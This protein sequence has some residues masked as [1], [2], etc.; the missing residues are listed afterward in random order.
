MKKILRCVSLLLLGLVPGACLAS[1]VVYEEDFSQFSN[2]NLPGQFGWLP[3]GS[4]NPLQ[5]AGA[6]EQTYV[7]GASSAVCYAQITNRWSI[8]HD[9]RTIVIEARVRARNGS[10]QLISPVTTSGTL[11]F[12]FGISATNAAF[13]LC[14]ADSSDRFLSNTNDQNR[15]GSN[16]PGRYTLRLT[17]DFA[18]QAATFEVKMDGST[19]YTTLTNGVNL[20]LG[21][22]ASQP[23]LW[24]GLQLRDGNSTNSPYLNLPGVDHFERLTVRYTRPGTTLIL[25]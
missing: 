12:S 20:G 7:T 16:F 18:S 4:F 15:L 25:Q 24:T 5:V 21:P 22:E 19:H 17:Y 23:N 11:A 10:D 14:G 6:P 9:A 8:P 2:G 1:V 3:V 13:R